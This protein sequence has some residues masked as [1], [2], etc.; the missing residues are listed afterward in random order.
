[1]KKFLAAL[2]AVLILSACGAEPSP[3]PEA[4]PTPPAAETPVQLP[5]VEEAPVDAPVYEE[6]T[7]EG[8]VEDTV[9]YIY[10]YPKFSQPKISGFYEELVAGLKDYA[11]QTVY[12]AASERHTIADVTGS[13]EVF[14][15]GSAVTVT[16]VVD[17]EYGDGETDRFDRT[18]RFDLSD[19]R[20]LEE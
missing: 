12:A 6:Q 18:D 17:V 9:A 4:E 5:P 2:G 11:G 3:V 15:D 16:Y 13:Y 19:G 20:R 10:A 14:A 1:M 8:L 7:A